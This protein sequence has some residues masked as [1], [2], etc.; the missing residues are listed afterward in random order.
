MLLWD[1]CIS[2]SM[3]VAICVSWALSLTLFFCWCLGCLLLSVFLSGRERKGMD[4]DGWRVL[5][6]KSLFNKMVKDEVG[7]FVCLFV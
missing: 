4:S 7:F 5:Y 3:S 2:E 1:L 6:E